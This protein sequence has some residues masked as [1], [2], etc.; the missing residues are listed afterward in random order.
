MLKTIF[1]MIAPFLDPNDTGG[2]GGAGLT[3][4]DVQRGKF[5]VM[6]DGGGRQTVERSAEEETDEERMENEGGASKA[7]ADRKGA[8]ADDDDDDADGDEGAKDEASEEDDDSEQDEGGESGE[9]DDEGWPVEEDEGADPSR[10]GRSG[11][12]EEDRLPQN[13]GVQSGRVDPRAQGEQDRYYGL[14]AEDYA[15]LTPGEKALLARVSRL[16]GGLT[17][18]LS[19]FEL[20][21]ERARRQQQI[22]IDNE[23]AETTTQALLKRNVLLS[24]KSNADIARM[25][26]DDVCE[27]WNHPNSRIGLRDLPRMIKEKAKRYAKILQSREPSK[28]SKNADAAV[29][30]AKN[31][32]RDTGAPVSGGKHG[33]GGKSSS[34]GNGQVRNRP[35]SVG[36]LT[37]K[38]LEKVGV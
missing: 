20:S 15:A 7:R 34:E 28:N 38:A 8:A 10:G 27:A 3:P 37:R 30:R 13:R 25:V 2:Q 4:N 9:Y 36:E 19:K 11:G 17:D 32:K 5:P 22:D 18:R 24:K 6:N 16:E 26:Y 1:W 33:G 12:V 23:K 21:Q 29:Q 14:S 35:A 31:A